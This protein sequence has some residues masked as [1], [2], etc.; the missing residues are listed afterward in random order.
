VNAIAV[1]VDAWNEDGHEDACV[2][3]LEEFHPKKMETFKCQ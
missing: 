3:W 1:G 2:E